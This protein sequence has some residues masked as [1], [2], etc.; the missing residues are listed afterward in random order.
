VTSARAHRQ[1]QMQ[2][3]VRTGSS[4]TKSTSSCSPISPSRPD[5]KSPFTSS[6]P[7]RSALMSR[8]RGATSLHGLPS[9]LLSTLPQI[10]PLG[11][12]RSVTSSDSSWY[13]RG[14]DRPDSGADDSPDCE[15][16]SSV[17][18]TSQSGESCA[19][20]AS[21]LAQSHEQT[22]EKRKTDRVRTSSNT[23]STLR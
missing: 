14:L 8:L 16:W 17:L 4:A 23:G 3:R 6:S 10:P 22:N 12:N 1:S 13:E 20:V 7:I 5:S 18:E 9:S 19:V 11:S 21:Q 2:E 15:C